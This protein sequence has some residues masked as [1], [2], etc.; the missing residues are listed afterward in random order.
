VA[1]FLLFYP[2]S[3]SVWLSSKSKKPAKERRKRQTHD[4]LSYLSYTRQ[5]AKVCPNTAKN[6]IPYLCHCAVDLLR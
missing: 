5:I 3:A 2:S 4:H 1:L 6:F